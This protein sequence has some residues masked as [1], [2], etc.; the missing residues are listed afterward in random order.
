MEQVKI[1]ILNALFP[2]AHPVA[3]R[4]YMMD[5]TRSLFKNANNVIKMHPLLFITFKTLYIFSTL[6]CS[7]TQ[8]HLRFSNFIKGLCITHQYILI[9]HKILFMHLKLTFTLVL[10]IYLYTYNAL[11]DA[12]IYMTIINTSWDSEY[13][14]NYFKCT[15]V[16]KPRFSKVQGYP[17]MKQL[18]EKFTLLS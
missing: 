18:V 16:F 4:M 10:K 6:E 7:Q 14:L 5:W 3:S 17:T 11:Q 13:K 12:G 15:F 2:N 9:F 1:F 8:F